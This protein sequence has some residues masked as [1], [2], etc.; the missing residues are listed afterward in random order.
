LLKGTIEVAAY[1]NYGYRDAQR[2]H[3]VFQIDDG[4]RATIVT[5]TWSAAKTVR[6][7]VSN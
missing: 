1:Y 3:Y 4:A 7:S 6:I 2:T 5:N